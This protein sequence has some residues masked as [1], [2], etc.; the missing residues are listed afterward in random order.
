MNEP[1]QQRLA[2]LRA[3]YDKGQERLRAL[4]RE[5]AELRETLLR[6]EGAMMVLNEMARLAPA[7][8]GADALSP[9]DPAP[10]GTP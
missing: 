9:P 4:H 10:L 2:T 5:E 7:S 3:E 8:S 6:I 1:I